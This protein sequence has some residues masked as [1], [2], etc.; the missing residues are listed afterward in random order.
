[1]NKE[2]NKECMLPVPPGA[3]IQE[4]MDLFHATEYALARWLK[5]PANYVKDLMAGK[6]IISD[7]IAGG[8]ESMLSCSVRFWLA[9]E[10]Q[11]RK[12]LFTLPVDYDDVTKTIQSYEK[13]FLHDY[14][15]RYFYII[16][17]SD[18][19][20]SKS[21]SEDEISL[22]FG[23]GQDW[24]SITVFGSNDGFYTATLLLQGIADFY[25]FSVRSKEL[26]LKETTG[27]ILNLRY[28]NDEAATDFMERAIMYKKEKI[29]ESL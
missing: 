1:M 22:K 4:Q 23:S 25:G 5:R 3:T 24:N 13:S 27:D 6:V 19:T 7:E 15:F 2:L 26:V 28:F 17:D 9:L 20:E 29:F 12:A 11:Y 10:R 21:L 14:I 8:L 16:E 18:V